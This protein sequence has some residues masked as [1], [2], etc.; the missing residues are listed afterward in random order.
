MLAIP[1]YT[2]CTSD[3]GL[4]QLW[5]LHNLMRTKKPMVQFTAHSSLCTAET[6]LL[7]YFQGLYTL[8]KR[9]AFKHMAY[10]NLKGLSHYWV[11]SLYKGHVSLLQPLQYGPGVSVSQRFHCIIIQLHVL[12]WP[13]DGVT[14]FVSC[15]QRNLIML[16][17]GVF[18]TSCQLRV[19][20]GQYQGIPLM[21]STDA[22]MPAGYDYTVLFFGLIYSQQFTFAILAH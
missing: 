15:M 19:G 22:I 14:S 2:I 6:S 10:N 1:P 16:H 17:V 18:T 4:P 12:N 9:E 21:C 11:H 3:N 20:K 13:W 8:N 7:E 5:N